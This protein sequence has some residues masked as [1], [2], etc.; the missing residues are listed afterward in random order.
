MIQKADA[1]SD[2][3]QYTKIHR[4]SLITMKNEWNVHVTRL[5]FAYHKIRIEANNF[6]ALMN[7]MH[8]KN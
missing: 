1:V 4:G 5:S 3:K 8:Q 7:K 2:V 6:Y